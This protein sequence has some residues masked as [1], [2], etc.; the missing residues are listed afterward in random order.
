MM[1]YNLYIEDPQYPSGPPKQCANHEFAERVIASYIEFA[2]LEL[3]VSFERY[4]F[5][6]LNSRTKSPTGLVWGYVERQKET[7]LSAD[8]TREITFRVEVTF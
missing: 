7:W 3:K 1:K 8:G 2:Q 5:S 4:E 6:Q